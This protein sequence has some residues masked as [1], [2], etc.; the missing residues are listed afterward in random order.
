MKGSKTKRFPRKKVL[1]RLAST[2]AELAKEYSSPKVKSTT[3]RTS[4]RTL[5]VGSSATSAEWVVNM[6]YYWAAFRNKG[7]KAFTM[8]KGKWIVFFRNSKDDPRLAGGHLKTVGER[9]RLNL[10]RRQFRGLKKANKI[11]FLKKMPAVE[12]EKFFE[13]TGGMAGLD[14]FIA[15]E[16]EKVFQEEVDDYLGEDLNLDITETFA[17]G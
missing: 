17:L 4:M 11:R 6:P 2:G 7:T 5:R 15:P 1:D 14:T 13:D 10:S 9:K 16:M 3:L 8:P 12:G